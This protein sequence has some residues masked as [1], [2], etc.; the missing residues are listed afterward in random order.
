MSWNH[1][2]R[3]LRST[4]LGAAAA[5]ALLLL[6]ATPA[7]AAQPQGKGHKP[8][9]SGSPSTGAGNDIGYPQCGG[10]FPTS[11]TFGIVGVNDG[12]ANNLNPCLG[13]DGGGYTTSELYWATTSTGSNTGSQPQAALY[14]NTA[15]PGSTYHH[16]RIADWPTAGTYSGDPYSDSSQA[17]YC[18]GGNTQACAWEYGYAKAHQ[19]GEWLTAEANALNTSLSHVG[20]ASIPTSPAAYPWWLDIE[21]G[22]TWQSGSSGQLMNVADIQGML[23]GLAAAGAKST[24][25]GI[26][27][28]SSQWGTIVGTQNNTT[29]GSLVGLPDWIPGASSLTGAQASCSLPTFTSGTVAVTQWFGSPYDGDWSCSAS[30]S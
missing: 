11:Q 9:S 15:D 1:H 7:L 20:L 3:I 2:T 10:T 23:A 27:S 4:A 18:N 26:Y 17:G 14:V 25:I 5:V 8:P 22:N 6:G 21:T 12:L 19:D 24:S 13:P 28:T 29:L 16:Q 30:P